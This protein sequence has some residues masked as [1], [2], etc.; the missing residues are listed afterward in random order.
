MAPIKNLPA[1]IFLFCVNYKY[2]SIILFVTSREVVNV[3]KTFVLCSNCGRK[4][5]SP[6]G[7]DTR[8]ELESA[9]LIADVVQCPGCGVITPA[10]KQ[11]VI[12]EED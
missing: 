8:E 3:G 11:N 7:F 1:D 9:I 2:N 5:P 6:F 4:L 12:F 10:V